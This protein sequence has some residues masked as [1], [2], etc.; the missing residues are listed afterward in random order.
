M[1]TTSNLIKMSVA[2]S[3]SAGKNLS[4]EYSA[5]FVVFQQQGENR[6][7]L[8]LHY[9]SGHFDFP[10][11]HLEAGENNLQAAL[12]E[13]EEETSLNQITIIPGFEEKITY[14]FRR[15]TGLVQKQVTFFLGQ[16]TETAIQLSHEHQGYLWLPY[17]EALQKI[18]FENA[19]TILRQAESHLNPISPKI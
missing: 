16:S 11:G 9:P 13:L 2:K 5:G 17:Q 4:Y 7:Y 1:K 10:K 8:I 15:Q 12:R 18:T 14:T 3:Q 19:R 6:Q